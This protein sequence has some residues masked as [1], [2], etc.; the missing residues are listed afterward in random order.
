MITR[1]DHAV[2]AARD[3]D[4]ARQL[5]AESLGFDV[6]PGGRHTGLGTENALVR[7]GLDYLELLA[8]YDREEVRTAGI[9][10]EAL[11]EYL[12]TREG[13]M[14]GFALATDDIDAL[15]DQFRR[16]GLDAVGPY[17]M[18][19]QRPDGV[20][21]RWRLLV[22]GGTAWRR[23]W[24]FF[25]QW[26]MD[27]QDR[28]AVE[29]P[30]NHPIG[31][32]RVCGVSVLVR[33]AGAGRH[34]YETQLGLSAEFEDDT[35]EGPIVTYRV[36]EFTIDLLCPADDTAAAHYLE[37]NGEGLYQ[38]MLQVESLNYVQNYLA[39]RGIAL[40][41]A[42]AEAAPWSIPASAA[43]GAQFVLIGPQEEA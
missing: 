19:R 27:G 17:D 23:P 26:E 5:F 37:A 10:R 22:P 2:I 16:T 36:G 40:T 1:F 8:I 42:G 25:I 41:R 30:G 14:L 43:L 21:L 24:P 33:D 39:E 12:E 11:A 13:G 34:L 6:Y 28:L 31:A 4:R 15:A 18:Q 29:V 35:D 7:F 38:V 3:L 32:Q 20:M 9:S